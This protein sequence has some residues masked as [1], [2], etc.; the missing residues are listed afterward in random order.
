MRRT[1]AR[2]SFFI[3][4]RKT[5]NGE[6]SRN[7]F[8]LFYKRPSDFGETD[9]TTWE[10]TKSMNI[11]PH[12]TSNSDEFYATIQQH[13][14]R[15]YAQS[16]P[17]KKWAI[18]RMRLRWDAEPP[19][20]AAPE[21]ISWALTHYELILGLELVFGG[22][23]DVYLIVEYKEELPPDLQLMLSNLN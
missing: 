6:P 12:L 20:G 14:M 1:P 16:H 3:K 22:R 23:R 19:G 9:L 11:T 10:F 18:Y 8:I 13:I 4:F 2:S 5:E 15:Y 7:F 17:E 21:Q